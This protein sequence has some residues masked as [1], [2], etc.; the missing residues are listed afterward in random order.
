MLRRFRPSIRLRL[1]LWN[2]SV[3]ALV[4]IAFATA[5]WF[6]LESVLRDRGDATVRESARAIAGA[7]VAE[8]SAARARGEV[9]RGRGEAPLPR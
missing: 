7:V 9:A 6:T 4:L 3:L 5:G 1:T 2:A 8:R